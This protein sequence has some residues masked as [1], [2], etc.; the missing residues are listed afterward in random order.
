MKIRVRARLGKRGPS[1]DWFWL[2]ATAAA[3]YV[4]FEHHIT[5]MCQMWLNIPDVC[6]SVAYWQTKKSHFAQTS[7]KNISISSILLSSSKIFKFEHHIANIWQ[8]H[9]TKYSR[10]LCKL[11]IFPDSKKVYPLLKLLTKHWE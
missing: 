10:C 5:N 6:A 11:C 7:Q 3:K 1:C 2:A 4:K 9:V 8:M